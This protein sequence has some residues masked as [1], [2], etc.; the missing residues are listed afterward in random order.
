MPKLKKFPRMSVWRRYAQ[1]R[2]VSA[3]TLP[4]GAHVRIKKWYAGKAMNFERGELACAPTY[5]KGG[6]CFLRFTVKLNKLNIFCCYDSWTIFWIIF[7]GGSRA[8]TSK[9]KSNVCSAGYRSSVV[10]FIIVTVLGSPHI[11]LYSLFL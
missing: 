11:I 6:N 1:I 5:R 4:P 10:P 9:A 8:Q 3:G 7:N 2:K